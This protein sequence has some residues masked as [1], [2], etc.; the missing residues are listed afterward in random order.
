M[1]VMQKEP[2][3]VEMGIIGDVNKL[4]GVVQR[5]GFRRA[6]QMVG[7]AARGRLMAVANKKRDAAYGLETQATVSPD[8]LDVESPHARDGFAYVAT[9]SKVIETF[10]ANLPDD[11]SAVT[12]IDMGSGKGRVLLL[13]SCHDFQETIGVE[14]SPELHDIACANIAKFASPRRKCKCVY[15]LNEDAAEY[16]IPSRSCAIYFN[17]PFTERVFTKVI[18][19]I[20]QSWRA[21]SSRMFI[22]YQQLRGEL[23]DDR[24]ANIELLESLPFLRE[25]TVRLQS[26]YDRFLLASYTL[27]LFETVDDEDTRR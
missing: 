1:V 12:F 24:T 26:V 6:Y 9:P 14:F 19:N 27:R 20:E 23:E 3:V 25:R 16:Q 4:A 2:G 18:Q 7:F 11:L 15:S 22:M 17:N 5:K 10:I 21:S 13:A 8:E